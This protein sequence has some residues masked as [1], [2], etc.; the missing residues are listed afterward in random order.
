M[1]YTSIR[2]DSMKNVDDENIES[3]IK[4]YDGALNFYKEKIEKK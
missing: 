2:G 1:V 4:D 3:F